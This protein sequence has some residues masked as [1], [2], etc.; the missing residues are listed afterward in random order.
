MTEHPEEQRLEAAKPLEV[1][2]YTRSGCHLCE[3][4]KTVIEP[5]LEEFGAKLREVNIE[6]DAVLTERYGLDIPVLFIGSRK[7]AKHRVDLEKFRRQLRDAR[8]KCGGG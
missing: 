4:A 3:V 1:T 5:A 8:E 6:G 2:L 7:A